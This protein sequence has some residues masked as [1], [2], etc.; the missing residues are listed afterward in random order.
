MIEVCQGPAA[1]FEN[2]TNN[3]RTS[4]LSPWDT[5]AN[6]TQQQQQGGVEVRAAS[7]IFVTRK[8]IKSKRGD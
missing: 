3:H 6:A 1:S 7:L 2:V 8:A 4:S 5:Y